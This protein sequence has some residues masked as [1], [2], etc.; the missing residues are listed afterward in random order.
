L[1]KKIRTARSRNDL[2][3]TD[4]K[5]WSREKIEK[6]NLFLIS[7][8]KNLLKKAKKE[9]KTIF[10]G[11]TH[12]QIAQPTTFGHYLMCY[13]EMFKRDIKKMNFFKELNNTCPL[14]SC[15]MTGT[16][17]NINRKKFIFKIRI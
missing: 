5:M 3:N 9:Y 15:A 8:L 7:F 4:L 10:P 2:V 6:L 14:G 13:Y 17:F 16:S 1:E 11:F 12:F